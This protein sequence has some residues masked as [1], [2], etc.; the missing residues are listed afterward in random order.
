MVKEYPKCICIFSRN[1]GGQLEFLKKVDSNNEMDKRGYWKVSCND[2]SRGSYTIISIVMDT[3]G[4][5]N[6]FRRLPIHLIHKLSTS[7]M[8]IFRKSERPFK[9]DAT[10]GTHLDFLPDHVAVDQVASITKV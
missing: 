10:P 7:G 1:D 4:G 6:S 2:L 8:N 5:V 9:C 3:S